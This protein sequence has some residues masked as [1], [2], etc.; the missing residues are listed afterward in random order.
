M[1]AAEANPLPDLASLGDRKRFQVL[2]SAVLLDVPVYLR[3]LFRHAW[4]HR[5]PDAP[6]CDHDRARGH[7]LLWGRDTVVLSDKG[8]CYQPNPRA[9]VKR[10]E[11]V[12]PGKDLRFKKQYTEGGPWG[13][14]LPDKSHVTIAGVAVVVDRVTFKGGNSLLKLEAPLPDSVSSTATLEVCGCSRKV[15]DLHTN[16]RSAVRYETSR[17]HI[18]EA[19]VEAFDSTLLCWAFVNSAHDGLPLGA[20]ERRGLLHGIEPLRTAVDNFRKNVRNKVAHAEPTATPNA[21]LRQS[22]DLLQAADDL[23]WPN[24]EPTVPRFLDGLKAEICLLYTSDAA[25]E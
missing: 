14:G 20:E 24:W 3:E 13:E 7:D 4:N 25:D 11:I 18:L 9:P 12:V 8:R 1:D 6:W 22:V 21:M 2:A 10:D 15:F 16:R 19:D 17:R 23:G 5:Y